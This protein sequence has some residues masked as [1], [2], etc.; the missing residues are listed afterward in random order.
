MTKYLLIVLVVLFPF[1]T[2][3]SATYQPNEAKWGWYASTPR[4]GTFVSK[5]IPIKVIE[6]TENKL[7]LEGVALTVYATPRNN[8]SHMLTAARITYIGDKIT[9]EQLK[10]IKYDE[11]FNIVS[12]NGYLN[13]GELLPDTVG[14]AIAQAF[15]SK[16]K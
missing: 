4:T 16:Y 8:V 15:K 10:Q 7:V 3:V 14:W 1:L 2:K 13:K 11:N 9:A 6:Q 5:E 12:N